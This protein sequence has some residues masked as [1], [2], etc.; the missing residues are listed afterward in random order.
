MMK[1][2]VLFQMAFFFQ[3][4]S[5]GFT[6]EH[7]SRQGCYGYFTFMSISCTNSRNL[8]Q[9]NMALKILGQLF[10]NVQTK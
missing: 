1:G 6:K 9:W 8:A 5:T 7:S 10:Q 4:K 2:K 3:K